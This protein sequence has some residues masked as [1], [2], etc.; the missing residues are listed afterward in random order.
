MS[1]AELANLTISTAGCYNEPTNETEKQ[2]ASGR[3]LYP[4]IYRR[5]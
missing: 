4:I 1:T 3:F 2:L 5:R